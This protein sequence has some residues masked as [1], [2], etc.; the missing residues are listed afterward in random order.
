MAATT[1]AAVR[2]ALRKDSAVSSTHREDAGFQRPSANAPI[3]VKYALA[4]TT[5]SLL[6]SAVKEELSDAPYAQCLAEGAEL[7]FRIGFLGP[8]RSSPLPSHTPK[9]SPAVFENLSLVRESVEGEVAA[10]RIQGP[11]DTPAFPVGICHPLHCVPKGDGIRLINNLSGPVGSSVNDGIPD[12]F[13]EV[14][15]PSADNVV[16]AIL[17]TQ[18][19]SNKPAMIAIFD[20][21]D[22]Y[23]SLRIH[24]SDHPLLQF[25]FQGKWYYDTRL[26]FGLRSACSLFMK[27]SNALAWKITRLFP[28][29]QCV[30]YLDD[31]G[32]VGPSESYVNEALDALSDLAVKLGLEPNVKK[33]MR[34]SPQASFLGLAF[35]C[36]NE[37]VALPPRKLEEIRSLV[38]SFL[39]KSK[40]TLRSLQSLIGSLNFVCYVKPAGRA[41]LRRLTDATCGVTMPEHRIRI[42]REMKKDLKMWVFFLNSFSGRSL[43][44]APSWLPQP[45]GSV[46]TDSSGNGWGLIFENMWTYGFF[47]VSLENCHISE[48]EL[49]PVLVFLLIFAK[50]LTN[51]RVMVWSDNTA[52]VSILNSCTSKNPFIMDM[53][54]RITLLCLDFNVLLSARHIAGSLNDGP[55]ALSRGNFVK[56]RSCH[57]HADLFPLPLPRAAAP[58]FFLTQR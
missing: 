37:S 47:P 19:Q 33:M 22:A 20:L 43:F 32:L 30:N 53:V 3:V 6:A 57:P 48:K 2:P 46:A 24:P 35:D 38:V 56:F 26:S 54:R 13:A 15:Y 52:V 7:G 42:T 1:T 14:C 10:G 36:T 29:I 16:S 34:A 28:S 21:K 12:Q 17:S 4:G 27:L 18:Q 23:R 8:N 44:L 45:R 11:F 55:D 25:N 50:S 41:F 31:F 39:S 58:R 9:H 49:Y 5:P 51:C 40:C